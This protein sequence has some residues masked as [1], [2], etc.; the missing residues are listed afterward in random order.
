MN[1]HSTPAVPAADMKLAII[2]PAYNAGKTIEQVFERIP[3]DVRSQVVRYIVVN[4]GSTD[5]TAEALRR[6]QQRWP[7]FVVLQ[8]E[9]NKGYGVAEKTLLRYVV[10]TDAEVVVLLHADGQYAPEEIPRLITPF[11]AENADMV[12][13]SRMMQ[14]GAALRGGMPFY[15]YLA[16]RCLTA[17]QN[18]VFGMHMAEFHSGYMLYARH[19]LRA[20][21][22]EQLAD[23]FCF[24]QEMLIMAKVKG[25]TIVQVPIPTHYGDE[26]SHLKPIR[27]G[28][29]VLTL[30]W[31]YR[32]GH[33]H[34]L[35][36]A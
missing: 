32:R 26:V 8:H 23:H 21:P 24:D 29:N 5:D 18:A 27:Y 30:V 33:Y 14:G 16:N 34:R 36:A 15:K 12:Q 6:L 9:G 22:F 28:L 7:N 35:A 19:A 4:D 13:G 31:A 2:M 1:P 10:E 25:L 20:I 3:P 11:A 17:V